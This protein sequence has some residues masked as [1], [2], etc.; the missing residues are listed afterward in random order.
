[1]EPGNYKKKLYQ[2]LLF[3]DI[4]LLLAA[5]ERN[6]RGEKLRLLHCDY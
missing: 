3:E 5:V 4:S 1:M 6:A 2:D